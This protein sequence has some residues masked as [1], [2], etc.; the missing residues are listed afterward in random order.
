MRIGIVIPVLN[1]FEKA[2]AAIE[3][4]HT[5]HDYEIK[6]I[7][8]YR[9]NQPLAAAWNQGLEWSLERHHSFT[10]IINDDI[11]F[12][13]QSIDNMVSSFLYL[14]QEDK[15]AMITGNNI[16][17]L[18]EDPME[19]LVYRTDMKAYQECPD[20]ACFMVRPTIKKRIGAFDENFAPAYFE[21]ND[22]HYRIGLAGLH[23]YNDVSAPYYHYGSQTQNASSVIPVVPP[24]AFDNNRSYYINKWGDVPGKEIFTHPYN[25]LDIEYYEWALVS[26]NPLSFWNPPC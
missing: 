2:I 8:Q 1:Q 9:M 10:L 26:K 5:Q 16:R 17:G 20:F 14:E 11:L 18:Y 7:P 22:Y 25:N 12:T 23:A 4:I 13:K 24:F 21:D 15:C 6:I 19:T 3:S